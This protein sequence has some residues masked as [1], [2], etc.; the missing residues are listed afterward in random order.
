MPNSLKSP[1][2]KFTSLGTP[3]W[4]V[5]KNSLRATNTPSV[6]LKPNG[7]PLIKILNFNNEEVYYP[8]EELW[9]LSSGAIMDR[10]GRPNRL[11]SEALYYSAAIGFG[12]S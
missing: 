8:I 2:A 5:E 12:Y 1:N 10:F 7:E 6:V 9:A 11:G 3:F 4:E